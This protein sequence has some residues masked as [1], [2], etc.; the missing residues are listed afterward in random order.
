M[1]QNIQGEQLARS[2]EEAF[3]RAGWPV[4][5]DTGGSFGDGITVGGPLAA[6][7]KS[8]ID[9]AT[10]YKVRIHGTATHIGVGIKAN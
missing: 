10:P 7:L 5:F 9:E 8:A 1:H 3:V 4:E 2:I 6:R